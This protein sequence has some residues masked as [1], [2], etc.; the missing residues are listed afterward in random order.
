MAL[1]L[2]MFTALS[3]ATSSFL[4]E[5]ILGNRM[6]FLGLL[7]FEFFMVI[8][9]NKN[10]EKKSA[11]EALGGLMLYSVIN[12]LTLSMIFFIYN[13]LSIAKAFFVVIIMF[14]IM[15][16]IGRSIKK[17]ITSVGVYLSIGLISL[18]IAMVF[19]LIFFIS[20]VDI[21]IS[22]F[23]IVLFLGL[24]IYETQKMKNISTIYPIDSEE[25]KKH[26][27]KSALSLYLNFINLLL[28]F[29]RLDR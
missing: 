14:I 10:I 19:N 25:S 3:V 21:I 23:G 13:P 2:T 7:L 22:I 28:F 26:S 5:L 16:F 15:T 1:S 27:I 4:S 29:L 6:I 20:I 17:D 8:S 11:Q 12:G 9:L 24:T 18:I